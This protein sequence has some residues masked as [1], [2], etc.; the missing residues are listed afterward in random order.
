V[1]EA[2]GDKGEK[3]ESKSGETGGEGE[4]WIGESGGNGEDRGDTGSYLEG[5]GNLSSG[6]GEE[7]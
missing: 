2:E 6:I 5:E 7:M 1:K 3:S 4:A